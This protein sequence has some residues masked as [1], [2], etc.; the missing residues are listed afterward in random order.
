MIWPGWA[1]FSSIPPA[2]AQRVFSKWFWVG[3][4]IVVSIIAIVTSY[5]RLP[6]TQHAMENMP[7]PPNANPEQFQR[8]IEM[9]MMAQRIFVWLAPVLTVILYAISALILFAMSS[10]LSVKAK[11]GELFNLIAGCSLIQALAAIASLVILKAKGEVS[12]IA[13]LQPALGLDIFMPEGTNK[14]L[15]AFLAS[16][17]IFEIW[18]IIMAV[19][20]FSHAF[21]VSKGKAFAAVLPLI[22]LG[23]LF[24]LVGAAFQRT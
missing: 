5:M 11:F 2:A 14:F 7:M 19:L 23:L 9:G 16:F 17:S 22:L 15:V 18:W 24:R 3:P 13:E 10:V 12:T 6:I 4:L 1:I 8:G 21:R 20:I